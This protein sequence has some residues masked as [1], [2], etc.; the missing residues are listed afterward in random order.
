MTVEM[1][2]EPGSTMGTIAYMSPEQARGQTV[3]ARSDLWSLGRGSVRNGDGH[4][5]F[6]G[7]TTVAVFDAILHNAPVSP[8]Q[9][10][11]E[12]PARLAE[13]INQALAKD[14]ELRYRNASALLSDLRGFGAGTDSVRVAE[15]PAVG[16]GARARYSRKAF[17]SL[18]VLP[19]ENAVSIPTPSISATESQKASFKAFRNSRKSA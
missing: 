19:F 8:L 2:T 5:P 13:I 12:T 4:D 16:S 9:L 1:L 11:P 7:S 10:N 6:T 15:I 3:D 17:D 18:A 14:R